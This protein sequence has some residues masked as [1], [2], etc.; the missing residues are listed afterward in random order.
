MLL[1]PNLFLCKH[2]CSVDVSHLPTLLARPPE[3]GESVQTWLQEVVPARCPLP[4]CF[5]SGPQALASKC[6][7]VCS[8]LVAAGHYPTACQVSP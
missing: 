3:A 6:T 5:H 4:E 7:G 2:A 8:G 1:L